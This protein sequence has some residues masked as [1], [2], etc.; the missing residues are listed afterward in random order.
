MASRRLSPS[1]SRSRSPIFNN[2]SPFST[3]TSLS[4]PLQPHTPTNMVSPLV[5]PRISELRNSISETTDLIVSATIEAPPPR[6]RSDGDVWLE[7]LRS[8]STTTITT[9]SSSTSP[10]TGSSP[11]VK[12]SRRASEPFE[13]FSSASRTTSMGLGLILSTTEEEDEDIDGVDEARL[14]GDRVPDWSDFKEHCFD[15]LPPPV[16]TRTQLR[17]HLA[18][19]LVRKLLVTVFVVSTVFGLSYFTFRAAR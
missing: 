7:L 16:Q 8:S 13:S 9:T 15:Q 5:A 11:K 19:P 14:F 3:C 4:T 2:H 18:D 12:V 6:R 1:E 17:R 10:K